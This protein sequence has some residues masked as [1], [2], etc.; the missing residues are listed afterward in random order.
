MAKVTRAFLGKDKGDMRYV[1]IY[2]HI[3]HTREWIDA[4]K[5][6]RVSVHNI[7]GHYLEFDGQLATN[8]IRHYE[9]W[10]DDETTF[11]DKKNEQELCDDV[12]DG[13]LRRLAS[14]SRASGGGN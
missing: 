12:P 7:S 3:T 1:V 4:N 5:C 14:R 6:Q 11:L 8:F 13:M 2:K 9:E 10:L